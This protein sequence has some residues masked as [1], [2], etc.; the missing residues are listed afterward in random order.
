[1]LLAMRAAAMDA[2]NGAAAVA[3][4]KLWREEMA[5]L[6]GETPATASEAVKVSFDP[7]GTN[8]QGGGDD[9]E[10]AAMA[11]EPEAEAPPAEKP[12]QPEA[13]AGAA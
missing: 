10:E 6:A 7:T 1:M 13:A 2:K 4:M 3:A 5:K 9:E 11:V 12:V 8:R